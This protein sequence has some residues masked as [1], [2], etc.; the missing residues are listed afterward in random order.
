M[1]VCFFFALIVMNMQDTGRSRTFG[2]LGRADIGEHVPA[3]RQQIAGQCVRDDTTAYAGG[4]I[5]VAVLAAG[6]LVLLALAIIRAR[7]PKRS[8]VVADDDQ[9]DRGPRASGR[10]FGGGAVGA[11]QGCPRAGPGAGVIGAVL[12]LLGVVGRT[13]SS[14]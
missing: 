4:L 10:W 13:P 1:G 3:G 5:I 12:I 8:E 6:G 7:E 11:G 14:G 2:L 9:S